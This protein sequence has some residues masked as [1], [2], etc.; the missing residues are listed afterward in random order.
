MSMATQE[1]SGEYGLG[2]RISTEKRRI[3]SERAKLDAEMQSLAR[4]AEIA[5]AQLPDVLKDFDERIAELQ[6]ERDRQV[7][8]LRASATRHRAD[9]EAARKRRDA[10][11]PA[12]SE[13]LK[14]LASEL[15]AARNSA[16]TSLSRHT[17]AHD[18]VLRARR[19][20][21]ATIGEQAVA[22]Y[23][24]IR[25]RRSTAKDAAESKAYTIAENSFRTQ[26][27][28][29]AQALDELRTP[30]PERVTLHVLANDEPERG[31]TLVLPMSP[32][33]IEAPDDT[34]W[35]LAAFLYDS[36][37]RAAREMGSSVCTG[38]VMGSL[39]A[40]IRPWPADPELV[41]V[42]LREAWEAR[43]TLGASFLLAH[44]LVA[45]VEP[46]I[47]SAEADFNGQDQAVGP[48]VGGS[49][50]SVAARL[51]IP[52]P[53]LVATLAANG[54]PFPD[55]RIDSMVEQSLRAVLHITPEPAAD[56]SSAAGP[57]VPAVDSSSPP[58]IARR[59]LIKLV[60]S[61]RI[62]GRYSEAD[63]V[64]GH[65]FAD[66]EKDLAREVI[67]RLVRAGILQAVR[68]SGKDFISIDPR[69]MS[70]VQCLIELRSN[71]ASLFD[72]LG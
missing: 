8:E 37:E 20:A 9:S 27:G 43:P 32:G 65:H 46:P 56:V 55:D 54:L 26:I 36:A 23:D 67:F 51:G 39:A 29:Y 66:N 12:S 2:T 10:I 15:A 28:A 25:R 6:N 17:N 14:I 60:R 33:D 68:K 52:I 58:A 19:E 44:E 47:E 3:E 63:N 21:V 59:A 16:S 70:D 7:A 42:A 64:W 40:E 61:H 4:R 72:G 5:E 1:R 48:A 35:R 71:D 41:V 38:E 24:E 62:G 53:D 57:A 34:R 49:L 18:H 30:E 45:G 11:P 31:V 50:R 69:R 22:E 13:V